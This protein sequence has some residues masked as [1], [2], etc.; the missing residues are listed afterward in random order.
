MAEEKTLVSLL[1]NPQS[2]RLK[3]TST[4]ESDSKT[5]TFR[6]FFIDHWLYFLLLAALVLVAY[7][8]SLGNGLVSDDK[9]LPEEG[10]N[11][12]NLGFIFSDPFAFLRVILYGVLYS[13]CDLG[14]ACLRATNI[15]WHLGNSWLVFVLISLFASRR[16][17]LATAVIF[18][19]HPILTEAI[20]WISGGGYAQYTFFFLLSFICYIQADRSKQNKYYL[21]SVVFFTLAHFSTNRLFLVPVFFLYEFLLGNISRNWKKLIPFL[22]LGGLWL[23]WYLLQLGTRTQSLTELTFADSG[24]VNIFIK[25]PV[26]I[27]TYLKLI[28]YPVPLTFY[29]SEP[30]NSLRILISFVVST[31][32]LGL[33]IY[34]LIKNKLLAFWLGFFILGLILSL[35]PFKVAQIVAERYAYIASLGIIF[36]V[37]YYLAKWLRESRK[38]LFLL[39][40]AVLVPTFL[41]RTMIRNTDWKNTDTLMLSTVR[42]TPESPRAQ[43]NVGAYYYRQGDYQKAATAFQAAL[44]ANPRFA[45]AYHNLGELQYMAGDYDKAIALNLE[46]LKHA[47]GL[48]QA[49]KSLG[50]AYLKKGDKENA[51]KALSLGLRV[52]PGSQEM[53]KLQEEVSK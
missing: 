33:F 23:G 21:L 52:N 20:T 50:E 9:G 27:T 4:E 15:L 39:L 34:G 51:L 22:F 46:A 37:V 11:L 44:R 47:P 18:A 43:N 12:W 14:A 7:T 13:V 48:W 28:F 5:F 16:V 42:T 26:A 17:A 10:A 36:L 45:D 30:I 6:Q 8:N 29:H 53:L 3:K 35:T 41:I 19:V 31:L 1:F 38:S 24:S 2:W 49:Y 32:F 40:I 25:I